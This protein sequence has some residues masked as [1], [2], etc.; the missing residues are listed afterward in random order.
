MKL[1]RTRAGTV[2]KLPR[3]WSRSAEE[4]AG[5]GLVRQWVDLSVVWPGNVLDWLWSGPSMDWIGDGLGRPGHDM[6]WS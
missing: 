2:L 5:Q 6:T 3:P 4:W 1:D